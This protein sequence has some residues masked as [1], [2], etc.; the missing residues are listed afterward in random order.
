MPVFSA[1][2]THQKVKK[3]KNWLEGTIKLNAQGNKALLYDETGSL[4]D[5]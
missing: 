4:I 5:R 2:Y 1:F 3:H